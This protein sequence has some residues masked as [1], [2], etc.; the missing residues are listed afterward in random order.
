[1]NPFATLLHLISRWV[2]STSINSRV[3]FLF[4]RV[5]R[6]QILLPVSLTGYVG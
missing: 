6:V 3:G 5:F 1:V 4:D 2:D